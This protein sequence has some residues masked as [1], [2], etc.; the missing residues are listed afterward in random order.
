[1][2]S[3]PPVT[4]SPT[5]RISNGLVAVI[6]TLS[7]AIALFAAVFHAARREASDRDP[8]L[9]A[10]VVRDAGRRHGAHTRPGGPRRTYVGVYAFHVPNLDLAANT[11]LVDFWVWFR[12]QGDDIDPS[13]TFEF[14]NQVSAWDTL[15]QFV[16]TDE[17]GHPRPEAL[18]GGWFYQVM[19]VQAR[20]G[21]PFDV[22]AF[23]FDEQDLVVAIEDTDQTVDGMIYVPDEGTNLVDPGLDVP[24]WRL[25]RIHTDVVEV[26]YATNFG[27]V[28]RPVGADRYTRFSY[29]MHIARPALAHLATTL[30][31]LN[32][33]ALIALLAFA[34][35]ASRLEA[36][37][38]VGVACL[39][40]TVALQL[41]ALGA[42]PRTGR[43]I[44]LDH[45]YNLTYLLLLLSLAG[46]VAAS[47]LTE[48]GRSDDAGRLDRA[49]LIGLAVLYFGAESAL[50]ATR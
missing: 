13:R 30:L 40:T 9:A 43:V 18:G 21:R 5:R 19:H 17:A 37:L 38:G 44:M 10:R 35:S 20:F 6:V 46:S 41:A 48:S 50:I 2:T 4:A 34:I 33:V 42:L 11:Y 32:L 31:P 23:P 29:T 1:M 24:G 14:M 47:R 26:A 15:R 7:L 3:N 16:Y 49:L 12:W 22:S 25:T 39:L 27:D 28:R 45:V 36:R 8:R